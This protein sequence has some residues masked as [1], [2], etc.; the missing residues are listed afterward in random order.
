MIKTHLYFDIINQIIN[1]HFLQV[2]ASCSTIILT[3]SECGIKVTKTETDKDESLNRCKQFDSF[4][5]RQ[6][7]STN[8]CHY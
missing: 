3:A 5:R 8:H 1:V 7:P 4:L 6:V 2:N